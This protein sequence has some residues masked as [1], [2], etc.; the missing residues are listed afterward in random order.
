MLQVQYQQ[1]QQA[2]T[3]WKSFKDHKMQ[4][5]MVGS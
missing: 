2:R 3:Q 5:E 1:Q 4:G